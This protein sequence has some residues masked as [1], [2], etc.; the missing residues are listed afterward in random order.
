MG[1]KK[2]GISKWGKVRAE[3]IFGLLFFFCWLKL[4]MMTPMN[5]FRVK[6]D[7]KMIKM[8]KYKYIY[9]FSSYTG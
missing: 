1:C 9:R 3:E 7:P 2:N 5:R 8:T 4:S 6:N